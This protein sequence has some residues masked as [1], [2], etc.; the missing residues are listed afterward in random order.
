M[1]SIFKNDI[2]EYDPQADKLGIGF[3]LYLICGFVIC[4]IIVF[5]LVW[6]DCW[7]VSFDFHTLVFGRDAGFCR[8][9]YFL[10]YMAGNFALLG[11]SILTP[12]RINGYIRRLRFKK[13]LRLLFIGFYIAATVFYIV[14]LCLY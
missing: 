9:Y 14:S 10:M 6:L 13:V 1:G 12:T 2:G 7:E 8:P 3:W 5:P 11:T 4:I